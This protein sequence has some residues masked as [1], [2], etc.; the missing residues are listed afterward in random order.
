[1]K[2]KN[3]IWS[4]GGSSTNGLEKYTI[5]KDVSTETINCDWQPGMGTVIPEHVISSKKL[6]WDQNFPQYFGDS[7]YSLRCLKKGVEIKTNKNLVIYNKTKF[8]G[9]NTTKGVLNTIRNLFSKRSHY[10]IKEFYIFLKT[11]NYS[12]CIL[13]YDKKVCI[14]HLRQYFKK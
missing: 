4:L 2:I 5:R 1:M 3:K 7:D 10:E 11:W 14:L 9:I 8:S 6:F 13:W 12:F